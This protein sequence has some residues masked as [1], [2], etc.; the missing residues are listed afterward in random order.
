MWCGQVFSS[1]TAVLAANYAILC[2]HRNAL[3]YLQFR[4]LLIRNIVFI[5]ED[6]QKSALNA[7]LR[8]EAEY[9][10]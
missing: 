2:A 3:T 6:V 1:E 7:A 10:F 4:L 9:E 8:K 5:A